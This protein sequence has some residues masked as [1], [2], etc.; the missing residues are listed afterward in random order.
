MGSSD[1]AN[2]YT[3]LCQ[4]AGVKSQPTYEHKKSGF[5]RFVPQ[6]GVEPAPAL[7]QTGF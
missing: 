7:L 1:S 5:R 3:N 6:A 2:K 4:I